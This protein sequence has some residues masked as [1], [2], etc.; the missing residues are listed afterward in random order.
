MIH[1]IFLFHSRT[2]HIDIIKVFYLPSDAQENCFKNNIKL[3]FKTAPT[4]FGA[5]TIIRGT[6]FEFAK[7]IFVKI[8]KIHRFG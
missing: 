8:I 1:N 2:V 5:I 7:G 3:Y 6:L 4:C